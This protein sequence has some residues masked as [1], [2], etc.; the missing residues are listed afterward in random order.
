MSKMI[1]ITT[2]AFVVALILS[3]LPALAEEFVVPVSNTSRGTSGIYGNDVDDYMSYHSFGDVAFDKWFG[4]VGWDGFANF[5]Y[6]RKFGGLYMGL[7]FHGQGFWQNGATRTETIIPRYFDTD[8]TLDWVETTIQYSNRG[9]ST[10]NGVY[11]LIGVAGMGIGVGVR[12]ET[13]TFDK[14]FDVFSETDTGGL[15]IA[16]NN[17]LDSFTRHHNRFTPVVGWGMKVDLDSLVIKPFAEIGLGINSNEY[18]RIRTG[19]TTVN[20][21]ISGREWLNSAGTIGIYGIGA[22]DPARPNIRPDIT[23]GAKLGFGRAE[24]GLKYNLGIDV[25]TNNSY[26]VF[27]IT[28]DVKG[29]ARWTAGNAYRNIDSSGY[30]TTTE[31]NLYIDLW[32]R[33]GNNHNIVPSFYYDWVL[34]ERVKLGFYGELPFSIGRG[35]VDSYAIGTNIYDV[36]IPTNTIGS[37]TTTTVENYYYGLT[38]TSTFS[39]YPSIAMGT[40]FVVI[41]EYF[42]LNA[43]FTFSPITFTKTTTQVTRNG[44]YTRHVTTVNGVG[45]LITNTVYSNINDAATDSLTETKS[46]G[47]MWATISAGFTINFT[48]KFFMDTVYVGFIGTNGFNLDLTSLSILFSIKK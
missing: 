12:V 18:E 21:V 11:A 31:E 36:Q 41:P 37:Y 4:W 29:T 15:S 48:P 2:L 13:W 30:S 9:F 40:Q 24:L 19:Y 35:K 3:V 14:P 6:A 45:N 7:L 33:S 42:K 16:L 39:L 8:G 17:K 27:G 20:G 22:A 26:D 46:W 1:K 25:Y 43:G 28:G 38:E 32:E 47:S 44:Y 23:L 10:D 34:N 5:G